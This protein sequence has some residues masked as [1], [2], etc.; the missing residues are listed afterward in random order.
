MK[1]M[2]EDQWPI[3]ALMGNE[4]AGKVLGIIGYGAI[5]RE[6]CRKTAAAN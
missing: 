6:T 4:T 1:K 2:V 3:T 5:G